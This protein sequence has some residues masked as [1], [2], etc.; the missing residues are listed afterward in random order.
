MKR[1]NFI[2]SMLLASGGMVISPRL[3]WAADDNR[4]IKKLVILHTNDMHSHIES[5]ADNDP[6][7]PGKGGIAKRATMIQKIRDE[8]A[9][10]LLLDCGDIFQGTPYFNYYLG[11]LEIKLM[12]EMKYDAATIG[13]HDFDGGLDNLGAKMQMADFKFLNCNYD[14]SGTPLKDQV[15]PYQIFKKGGL[16]IGVLGVGI[17]LEGLVD[18]KLYGSIG[19]LDPVE[20]AN[21]VAK[22]LKHEKNCDLVICLSH[23]GYEYKNAQISDLVLASQSTDIDIILG[24]HTHTFLKEGVKVD[25]KSGKKILVSQA[26]WAGLILGRVDV[27]IYPETLEVS[28]FSGINEIL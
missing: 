7:Y 26:G 6:N 23:L 19:Y 20:N 27:E 15:M 3:T 11:E 1:R 21:R 28:A 12:N 25:N 10:T 4:K 13:N 9:A 8:G 5:F 14:L 17:K 16:K 22:I 2:Q 24:G 18:K